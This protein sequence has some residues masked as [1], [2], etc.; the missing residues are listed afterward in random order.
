LKCCNE[1]SDFYNECEDESEKEGIRLVLGALSYPIKQIIANCGDDY[2]KIIKEIEKNNFSV[3]YN[4]KTSKFE[5]L[6]ETGII[7]PTTVAKTA[8]INAV[9]VA[10][11]LLTT[12]CVITSEDNE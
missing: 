1:L 9:S 10:S 4:A 12:E 3:G 5:N 7:D 8:I 6:K 11:M 2:N